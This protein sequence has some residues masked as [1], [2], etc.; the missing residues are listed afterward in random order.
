MNLKKKKKKRWLLI[1]LFLVNKAGFLFENN[2]GPR[3]YRDF[4]N[5]NK[6]INKHVI[7]VVGIFKIC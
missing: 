2:L 7:V 4:V 6:T 5:L 1:D 3:S